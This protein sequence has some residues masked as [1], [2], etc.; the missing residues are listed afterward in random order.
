MVS[1]GWFATYGAPLLRGRDFRADDLTGTRP[2]AIVNEA[3]V[4]RFMGGRS[5]LDRTV[6]LE[7]EPD[8]RYV[9]VGVAGDVAA[10]SLRD[11]VGPALYVPLGRAGDLVTL[12]GAVTLRTP[13]SGIFTVAARA[14]RGAPAALAGSVVAA[15][16]EVDPTLT[17]EV[18]TLAA[19]VDG[20]LRQ[21]RLTAVVAGLFGGLALLLAAVGLYGVTL[22]ALRRRR[23]E[24]GLRM[25]LGA[26]RGRVLGGALLRVG[27]LVG[28]GVAL[29]APASFAAGRSLGTL[30]HGV[31]PH[32]PATLA[33]AAG[34][35]V[36]AG[37]G[38]GLAAAVPAV[39][40]DPSR[41]LRQG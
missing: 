30:L 12:G 14:E 26:T 31:E 16:R 34:V 10:E 40:M 7:F 23:V 37:V 25:A 11:A 13:E 18:R 36:L 5:P 20:T 41:A 1:P 9:V 6:G 28:A 39:R 4:R 19:Q 17:S 3:F 22:L 15:I 8:R 38:A 32:D 29:G 2:A 27:A 24:I 21:E 35:L 33:A